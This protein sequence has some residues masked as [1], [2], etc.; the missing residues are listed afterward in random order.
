MQ[1]SALY[2]Y[3]YFKSSWQLVVF[4]A[5]LNSVLVATLR[6]QD[7]LAA[8][9]WQKGKVPFQTWDLRQE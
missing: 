7:T 4:S 5:I 8:L 2:V 1:V 6:H 3:F 9:E